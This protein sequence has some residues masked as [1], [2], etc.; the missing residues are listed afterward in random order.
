MSPETIFKGEWLTKFIITVTSEGETGGMIREEICIILATLLFL[1]LNF[2]IVLH[3]LH[4]Y[5]IITYCLC[6]LGDDSPLDDYFS[7]F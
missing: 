2:I 6:N 5:Y 3:S 4:M 1:K 7:A